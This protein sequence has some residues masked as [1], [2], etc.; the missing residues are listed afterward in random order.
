[1]PTAFPLTSTMPTDREI[2]LT[3]LFDAPPALVYEALTS[4]ALLPRWYF[5]TGWTLETC[6]V[7]LR[8]GRSTGDSDD[9]DQRGF[10]HGITTEPSTASGPTSRRSALF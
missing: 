5:P 4:P 1:M 10:S 7:D 2:V 3:R 6:E 9:C 8:E